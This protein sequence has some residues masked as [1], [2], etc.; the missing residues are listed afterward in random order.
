MYKKNQEII[1]D[2]RLKF[3]KSYMILA[4]KRGNHQWYLWE[5]RF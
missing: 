5:S 3:G 4:Y 1:Y 2:P